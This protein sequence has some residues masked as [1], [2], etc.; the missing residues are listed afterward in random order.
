MATDQM[1]LSGPPTKK[2]HVE[3]ESQIPKMYEMIRDQMKTLASTHNI[4][5]TIDHNCEVLGS[6][7]MAA[8]TNNRDL[9]PVDKYWFFM[10]QPGAEVMTE[11][12]IDIQPQMQWAKG[13]VH[14]PKY[15]GQWYP[16]LALLQLSN[17]TKDT[18]LWQKYPVTQELE[19]NNS[20]EIYANGHGIKDRLKNSRPRSVG[21]LVHLLHLKRL[22]ENPPKNPKTKKH[23]ESNAVNGIRKSIVSHLKRQCIGETQ[24]AMINQFEMGRWESLSTFAASLLAI[25]PRIENHFVL[26]YPLV[27]NCEDFAGA[28][29][30]DEWVFK[31]MEKIARK[32]TLRICGPD[33]KWASFINQ[34]TIHCVFQTAG[35]DLGVLEWVFGGR[36]NQRKE[37]GR[38]CKKSQTKVI[39]L[40][41]F[42]YVH[43][44][45]PL[46]AAPRSI[47]G[48]KRGQ[49][50]CRPSF[51]G[52]RPSYNNFTSIDA[53]QSAS[54]SQATNFYDQVREE[55]QKYMDLRVEGTTCF[56][57][58]GGT[59]EIEFPGSLSCNTYLFG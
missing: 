18:I 24:K 27:A 47:E 30:S 35:E 59:T 46:K 34:I 13:A 55:C 51:K 3:N 50:S 23:L 49:I 56:Y 7:I 11:V 28:T 9:R 29:L 37:F 6:I 52:K 17:K 39:G 31:T 43:W 20:L 26:T 16:F 21:P 15:K 54:S 12:E 53:I 32:G 36:F 14:D 45:K 41:A 8:C 19:L 40:F 58:K 57:K 10:G 2:P 22:Q 42:Q 25:K 4:P 48:A 38:Y 1:D 5:L 44:S 33:E